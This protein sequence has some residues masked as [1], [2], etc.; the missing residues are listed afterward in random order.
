[1]ELDTPGE[2]F[3]NNST[4]ELFVIPKNPTEFEAIISGNQNTRDIFGVVLDIGIVLGNTTSFVNINNLAIRRFSSQGIY[5]VANNKNIRIQSVHI[6]EIVQD[7]IRFEKG[8]TFLL[9]VLHYR[10]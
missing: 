2:W 3:F 7:G 8:M 6:S 10:G 5:G 9:S 1:M 4:A